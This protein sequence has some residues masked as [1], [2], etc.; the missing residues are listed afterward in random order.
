MGSSKGMPIFN[1][2]E[3]QHL[4]ES[5]REKLKKDALEE[6]RTNQEI[7]DLLK[8]NP[9]VFANRPE[10]REVVRKKLKSWVES[11]KS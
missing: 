3:L 11:K 9:E 1:D 7:R 8:T 5:D 4:S 10:V 2:D 6:I